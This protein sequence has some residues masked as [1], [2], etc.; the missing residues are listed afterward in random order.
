MP[1]HCRGLAPTPQQRTTRPLQTRGCSN[2]RDSVPKTLE[3][4]LAPFQSPIFFVME[5]T[6]FEEILKLNKIYRKNCLDKWVHLRLSTYQNYILQFH[7]L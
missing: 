7:L 4:G 2:Y 6:G 3:K 1:R 5:S